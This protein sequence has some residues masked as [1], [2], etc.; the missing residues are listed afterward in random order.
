[1]SDNRIDMMRNSIK[2]A[3]VTFTLVF[4]SSISFAWNDSSKSLGNN[5]NSKPNVALNKAA[6]CSPASTLSQLNLNN[7]NALIETGGSMWQDRSTND[8]SYIVPASSGNSSIYAGAL[9]LAGVDVNNQLKIAAL[10]FRSGNDFWTGPLTT[11]PGTGNGSDIRDF[12][13]A[14]IE[15]DVCDQYDKFFQTTRQEI[16]EFR[17]WFRCGEDP[18]C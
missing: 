1:M 11:I 15:P 3:T 18:D 12:G 14:E 17:G 9:W 8:G 10:Q 2:I 16:A 7:V 6:N 13:P 4:A 5:N